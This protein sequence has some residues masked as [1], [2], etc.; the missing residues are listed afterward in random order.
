MIWNLR[1]KKLRSGF[2][3]VEVLAASTIFVLGAS[4]SLKV[5]SSSIQSTQGAIEIEKIV[6][7]ATAE[8]EQQRSRLLPSAMNKTIGD[9]TLNTAV[10]GCN[11]TGTR[12]SCL[13]TCNDKVPVCK[14]V[15]TVTNTVTNEVETL[16]TL[17]LTEQL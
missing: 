4:A 3:L 7:L 17:K 16:T 8:I 5:L 14:I 9:F 15:V 12:I 6:T 11:F 1:I 2:S 13:S 10:N